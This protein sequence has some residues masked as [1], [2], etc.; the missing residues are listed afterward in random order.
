MVVDASAM[1]EALLRTVGAD[2]STLTPFRVLQ[3]A[4]LSAA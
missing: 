4:I 1:R 3:G 2:K